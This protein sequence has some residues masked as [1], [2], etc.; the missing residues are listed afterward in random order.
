M[1]YFCPN[2]LREVLYLGAF[3]CIAGF[4][5]NFVDNR[6]QYEKIG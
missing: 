1:S 2:F 3:A 5:L 4:Q 6:L